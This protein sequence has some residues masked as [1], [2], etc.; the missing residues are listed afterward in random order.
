MMPTV[1]EMLLEAAELYKSKNMLYGDSYRRTG[2]LLEELFP[3]GIELK[4]SDDFNRF[5]I[6][7]LILGKITRYSN[8]WNNTDTEDTMLDLSVY[9]TMLRELDNEHNGH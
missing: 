9:A 1:P 3:S 8:H 7:T 6:F 2:M 5:S 4:T